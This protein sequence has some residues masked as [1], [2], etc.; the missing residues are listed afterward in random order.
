MA[1][2]RRTVHHPPSGD[3]QRSGNR[4]AEY[5]HLPNASLRRAHHRHALA[6]AQRGSATPSRG[7]APGQAPRGGGGA[8]SRADPGV[9]R[10]GPDARRARRAPAGRV[11]QP[12]P[13]RAR[14]RGHGRSGSTGK[15][16]H[17]AG[18]LRRARRA[19]QGR[20]VRRSH[21]VLFAG[22]RFSGVPPDVH[23]DAEEAHLPDDGRR[24]SAAGGR[25]ISARRAS[26]SFCR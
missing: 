23:H 4:R 8:E 7:R 6:A 21:R 18:G 2:R 11:S 9:C 12:A 1:R 13:Y 19:P 20:T 24:Y 10:D 26:A 22:G 15:R 5:R 16:A 14:E 17:R 25:A 3:H